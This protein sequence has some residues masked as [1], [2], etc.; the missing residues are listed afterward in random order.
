[1]RARDGHLAF[2]QLGDEREGSPRDLM[3]VARCP[4]YREVRLGVQI[5]H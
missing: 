3:V 1:M 2:L 4:E 5:L